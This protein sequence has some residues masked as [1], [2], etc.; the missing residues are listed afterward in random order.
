MTIE[1]TIEKAAAGPVPAR[2][3]PKTPLR[4]HVEQLKVG[5]VLRWRPTGPVQNVA[6]RCAYS[7]AKAH[8]FALTV[9]KV[10]GGYDIYRTA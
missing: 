8:G 2:G 3:A 6:H 9:R 4:L 5:E 7:A 1:F 10:D